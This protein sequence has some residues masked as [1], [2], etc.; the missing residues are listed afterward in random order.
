MA[1]HGSYDLGIFIHAAWFFVLFFLSTE[2]ETPRI[3]I[4]SY[5]FSFHFFDV[6]NV[7][8]TLP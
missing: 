4:L 2:A 1:I 7:W 8:S 3:L 5:Y 6:V